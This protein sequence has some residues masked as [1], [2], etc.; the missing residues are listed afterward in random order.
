MKLNYSES[1]LVIIGSWN[2]SIVNPPWIGTHLIE[3]TDFDN[4]SIKMDLVGNN[5][6]SIRD[7]SISASFD[8][9]KII[10]IG[11]RLEFRLEMG[12][13]FNLLEKYALK[14]FRLLPNT[15]V[16]GYGINFHFYD[17]RINETILNTIDTKIFSDLNMQ[18]ITQ[19]SNL[20]FNLDDMVMNIS[21]NID[22]QNNASGVGFNFHFNI[23]RL[24]IFESLLSQHSMFNLKERAINVLSD[25][26][27]LKVEV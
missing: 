24:S 18:L 25:V 15:F 6:L 2:P 20:G 14:T 4:Q 9:I 1:S 23:D 21:T 22:K 19:Q 16:T 26:Y 3:A 7:A 5:T 27:G 12:D 17:E 10:L 11:N 8:G 13:D